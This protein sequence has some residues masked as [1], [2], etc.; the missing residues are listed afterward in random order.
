MSLISN[1][2][3]KA[4][5]S[6]LRRRFLI[7][8]DLERPPNDRQNFSAKYPM[9]GVASPLSK[10]AMLGT[11]P[12]TLNTLLTNLGTIPQFD[13]SDAMDAREWIE[14][15]EW[16]SEINSWTDPV[17]C[18]LIPGHLQGSVKEW[19]QSL[20]LASDETFPNSRSNFC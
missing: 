6:Q 19:Y 11:L 3:P 18:A 13:G 15:F 20:T 9:L 14:Q 5:T 2:K 12:A 4:L 17:K 10:P 8:V 1:R 7:D 16:T